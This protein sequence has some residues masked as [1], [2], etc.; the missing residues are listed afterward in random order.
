M[1]AGIPLIALTWTR[2]A[3]HTIICVAIIVPVK[4]TRVLHSRVPRMQLI[5]GTFVACATLMFFTTLTYLPLAEATAINFLAPLM[6]LTVAPFLLKEKTRLARWIAASIAFCGVLLIIRPGGGLHPLG[7]LLGLSTACLMCGQHV[8]TR[9]IAGDDPFTSLIWSGA[10][11]TLLLTP[12]LV[13]QWDQVWTT[14]QSLTVLQWVIL[15]STGL[16]GSIGHL[17]QIMG[18]RNAPASTLAPFIYT[19]IV[20]ATAFGWL[21]WGHFPDG[22]SWL[23]ILII[24][25]S[26]VGIAL[27]EWH[28]ARRQRHLARV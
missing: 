14:L 8:C 15:A 11:A 1:G 7:T 27:Y 17:L 4:G 6:T 21:V 26:G 13:W 24:C 16:T 19:Q 23:G 2:Y 22:L 3:M 5:R 18:Y 10:F 28:Y 12:V 25:L 20:S 9:K